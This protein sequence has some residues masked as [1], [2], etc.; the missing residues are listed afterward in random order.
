MNHYVLLG[1]HL[2]K[3]FDD[4]ELGQPFEHITVNSCKVFPRASFW[5]SYC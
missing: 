1:N 5:M 3:A 4:T 2:L